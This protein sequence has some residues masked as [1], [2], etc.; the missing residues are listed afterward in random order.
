[1]I[2]IREEGDAVEWLPSASVNGPREKYQN[3]IKELT[4]GIHV[5]SCA[6]DSWMR[7]FLR[8]SLHACGRNVKQTELI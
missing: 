1:M 3:E 5:G 8:Y 2:H 4:D 6:P 7:F